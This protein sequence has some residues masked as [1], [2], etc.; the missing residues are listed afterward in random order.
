MPKNYIM[1]KISYKNSLVPVE[2]QDY[3]YNFIDTPGLFDFGVEVDGALRAARIAL[4]CEGVKRT[5][6]QHP[7]GLIVIPSDMD[8]TD[9]TP[10]GY[11]ADDIGKEWKTTHFAFEAIHDNVLKLDILGHDDPTFIKKLIE[12]VQASPDDFPFKDKDDRFKVDDY[13][14]S[15]NDNYKEKKSYVDDLNNSTEEVKNDYSYPPVNFISS[16]SHTDRFSGL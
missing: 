12:Y 2:Y 8:V 13:S 3:K 6:G 4:M 14:S 16:R 15:W 10:V 11:P 1:H 5:T 9:F 7:G